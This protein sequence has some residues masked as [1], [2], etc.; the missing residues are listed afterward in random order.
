M[1]SYL[2]YPNENEMDKLLT[3]VI[4]S[5]IVSLKI[6]AICE[7]RRV[8]TSSVGGIEQTYITW[9]FVYDSVSVF[10]LASIF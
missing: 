7:T 2:R 1:P 4:E 5:C 3:S 8:T 9:H 6:K 10:T